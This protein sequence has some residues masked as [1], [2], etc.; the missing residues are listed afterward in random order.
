[1]IDLSREKKEEL[2]NINKNEKIA[3]CEIKEKKK[4][5]SSFI[6]Q[7][8][9]TRLKNIL[10]TELIKYCILND[11]PEITRLFNHLDSTNDQNEFLE[12]LKNYS[13]K[14]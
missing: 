8:S 11:E 14:A 12:S 6:D 4:E 13:S 5:R 1:M 9:Q 3:E 7:I 10:K 2:D